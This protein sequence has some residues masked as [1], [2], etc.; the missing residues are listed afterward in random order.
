MGFG[1][2]IGWAIEGEI[3]SCINKVEA[4]YLSPNVSIAARLEYATKSIRSF[5]TNFRGFI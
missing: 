5:H 2:N 3:G 4:S 1:L